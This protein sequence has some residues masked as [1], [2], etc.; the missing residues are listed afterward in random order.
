V[1]ESREREEGD[2][3]RAEL[4]EQVCME[5]EQLEREDHELEE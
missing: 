3:E 1:P 5:D 4:K 2:W